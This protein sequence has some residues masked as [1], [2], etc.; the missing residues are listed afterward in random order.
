MHVLAI[1]EEGA[2]RR[3]VMTFRSEGD[4]LEVLR[5]AGPPFYPLGWSHNAMAMNLDERTDWGEVGE[6]VTDSFCVMAPKKL[7]AQVDR[8]TGN[9]EPPHG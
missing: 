4:E 7:V 3:V 2:D 5:N 8:P 6:L 9:D 1:D